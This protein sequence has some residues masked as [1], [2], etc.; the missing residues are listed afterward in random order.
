VREKS[1]SRPVFK[2]ASRVAPKT[3]SDLTQE[4][5]HLDGEEI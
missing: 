3:A 4:N 2:A 1:G 5:A